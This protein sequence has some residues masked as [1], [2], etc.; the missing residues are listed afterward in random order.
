MGKPV[1]TAIKPETITLTDSETTSFS[2]VKDCFNHKYEK[3]QNKTPPKPNLLKFMTPETIDADLDR[4]N[5]RFALVYEYYF[6][7]GTECHELKQ[8][9][10]DVC[11]E[12]ILAWEN[13][14]NLSKEYNLLLDKAKN[15]ENLID[16]FQIE[17]NQL[18]TKLMKLQEKN[19]K[20]QE[21]TIMHKNQ[22]SAKGLLARKIAQKYQGQSLKRARDAYKLDDDPSSAKQLKKT[23]EKKYEFFYDVDIFDH[24][25]EKGLIRINNRTKKDYDLSMFV[26]AS[27]FNG[28]EIIRYTFKPKSV[29]KPGQILNLWNTTISKSTSKQQIVDEIHL[30]IIDY[31][32]QKENKENSF[33][34]LNASYL[35]SSYDEIISSSLNMDNMVVDLL[36]DPN[37]NVIINI[38]YI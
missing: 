27:F 24:N 29:L 23:D 25:I 20:L 5:Q 21:H 12:N 38:N 1:S 30:S 8:M 16:H 13:V 31:Q 9:L 7:K 3:R 26:L 28:V 18:K 22:A 34:I 33:A 37:G 19:I 2:D 6:T 4:I 32:I 10:E 14:A 35:C 17:M 36:Y 11:Q 15:Q